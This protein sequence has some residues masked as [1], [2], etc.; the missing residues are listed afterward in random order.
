MLIDTMFARDMYHVYEIN[1]DWLISLR[2]NS[3]LKEYNDVKSLSHAFK[4]FQLKLGR[5]VG[6]LFVYIKT[7]AC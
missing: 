7:Y 2:R 1:D 5:V 4:L 3:S 6:Q